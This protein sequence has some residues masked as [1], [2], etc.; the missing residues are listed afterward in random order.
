MSLIANQIRVERQGRTLVSNAS[1]E[2][3]PGQIH[4][5]LGPNGSGKST[6]LRALAGLW[7]IA[8]GSVLLYGKPLAAQARQDVARAISYV[9][10]DT[11]IDFAFTVLEIVAMG[12]FPH[13]GRFQHESAADRAAI[14]QALR[15]CDIEALA[16]RPANQLS[17]GERQRV[18]IARGLAAQPRYLLLDEP[19]ANLDIRHALE[20]YQLAQHLAASGHG[21]AI[22]THD[23]A[24]AMRFGT[25]ASL[26]C[27]GSTI[28]TGAP[29]DVLTEANIREVFGVETEPVAT[30]AGIVLHAKGTA[31]PV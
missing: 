12:R 10:Q 27:K 3:A 15:L 7:P 14:E 13:R 24:S 21:L 8:A 9:P 19:A 5:L 20:I 17:G 26:A 16:S 2:L 18:L 6:L 28:A 30:S 23:L 31:P 11:R 4:M 1:L 25:Q 29:G 22:A